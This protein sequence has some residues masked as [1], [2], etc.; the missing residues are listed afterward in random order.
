MEKKEVYKKLL[1]IQQKLKAP[2]GQFNDFGKYRYRSCEDILEEIKPHLAR[3]NAILYFTD[4]IESVGNR[5][6]IRTELHFVDINSGEE[7]INSAYAREEEDKKGMDGSQI[8]GASSS[9][10]R[11]YA[12]NGLFAIDDTK[13]SDTTNKGDEKPVKEYST[14][15]EPVNDEIKQTTLRN[16]GDFI[17]PFGKNKG[18]SIKQ[19]YGEEKDKEYG[20]LDWCMDADFVKQDIKD[21]IAQ[22]LEDVD[23]GY[24]P[25]LEEVEIETE[26]LPF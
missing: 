10:A 17:F 7:L 5:N 4:K 15:K 9:Y 22:F 24:D 12:L 8:T 23:T 16:A 1:N 13:D 11:K 18:K 6:Y 20:Y 26:E 19:I 25:E 14:K 2:K 3:E 21:L